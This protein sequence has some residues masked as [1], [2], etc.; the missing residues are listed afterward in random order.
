MSVHV[1]DWVTPLPEGVLLGR[2]QLGD[3][4][5]GLRGFRQP[6]DAAGYRGPV[7]VEIFSPALWAR[8][9]AEVLRK[10]VERYRGHVD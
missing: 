3:G 9:G 8:D 6:A 2:G 1:A 5:V 4:S 7:E 10:V